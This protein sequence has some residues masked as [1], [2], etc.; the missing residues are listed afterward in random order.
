MALTKV[1]YAM[2]KGAVANVLDFGAVG[3]G[4]TD[5]SDAVLAAFQ[6]GN[7]YFPNDTTY[8]LNDELI[9][10]SNSVICTFGDNVKFINGRLNFQPTDTQKRVI[11][12]GD[13]NI[14]DGS[15][16][17]GGAPDPAHTDPLVP[18]SN[19]VTFT[20]D[21]INVV[22]MYTTGG[23]TTSVYLS[24]LKN[25]ITGVISVSGTSGGVAASQAVLCQDIYDSQLTGF[26]ANGG[27]VM[28]VHFDSSSVRAAYSLCRTSVGFVNATKNIPDESGDHGCYC[29]GAYKSSLGNVSALGWGDT[30]ASCADFKFRD[31]ES[32][33]VRSVSVGRFRITADN[34]YS[35]FTQ[36]NQNN[37]FEDVSA[38]ISMST[39]STSPGY[40]LNNVFKAVRVQNLSMDSNQSTQ[41]GYIFTGVCSIR[42]DTSGQ[43]INATGLTF[44]DANVTLT[45]SPDFVGLFFNAQ[46]TTFNSNL[47][48][49]PTGTSVSTMSNVTVNGTYTHDGGSTTH[50]F[51]W[52]NCYISGVI[53]IAGLGVARVTTANW[54]YVGSGADEAGAG[55]VPEVKKYR[56][57]SF[58]NVVYDLV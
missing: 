50:N 24:N 31:N 8:D 27:W 14:E 35:F 39:V 5:D 43:D 47:S 2:I 26:N 12:N 51:N 46:N 11:F 57:V 18:D 16:K 45:N 37:V 6:T 21:N 7:V 33:Y 40:S 20:C 15:V 30:I 13:L 1:T 52:N 10:V 34:N 54:Y 44:R 58:N 49:A 41:N 55:F 19:A 4:V 42:V 28:G 48:F 17:I 25:S 22:N 29:H 56:Y 32:C 3:D 53:S 9:S 23:N 38:S 36:I